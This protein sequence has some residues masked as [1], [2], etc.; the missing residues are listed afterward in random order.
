MELIILI[1]EETDSKLIQ[2]IFRKTKSAT[3]KIK[4]G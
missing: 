3:E 1:I 2:N 4:A